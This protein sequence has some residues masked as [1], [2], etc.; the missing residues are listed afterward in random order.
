MAK[1]SEM[2]FA[3]A[4][5]RL[6]APLEW[7]LKTQDACA[8]P[9]KKIMPRPKLS[10]P[11]N[12][13]L[14]LHFTASELA[15]IK[16]RAETLGMKP[17]HFGRSLLLAE[18]GITHQHE[19]VLRTARHVVSQLSRIGNNLNQMMRHLHTTGDPVPDDLEPL[20]IDIRAIIARGPLP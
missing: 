1:G 10:D 15:S 16:R 14:N 20:L 4:K 2:C 13:Q 18:K 19:D 8:L 6:G 5:P 12:R 9:R 11:R 7:P 3:Y 17:V